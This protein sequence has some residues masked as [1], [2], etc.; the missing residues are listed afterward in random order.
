MP[1]V[2]ALASAQSHL[3]RHLRSLA[4]NTSFDSKL[5][6]QLRFEYMLFSFPFYNVMVILF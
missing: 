4:A 1:M 5:D 2:L 6:M 3:P